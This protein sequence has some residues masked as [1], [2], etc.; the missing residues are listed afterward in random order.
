MHILHD[1]RSSVAVRHACLWTVLMIGAIAIGVLFGYGALEHYD[2]ASR[3]VL[4]A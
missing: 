1:Q 3:W 2:H 4:R